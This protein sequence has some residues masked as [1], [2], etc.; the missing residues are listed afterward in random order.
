M[1]YCYDRRTGR[2]VCDS[3]GRSQDVR[4]RKCKYKVT[5]HTGLTLPYCYP[6]AL[7]PTCYKAEGGLSGVHGETCRTGAAASQARDDLVGATLAA[8]GAISTVGYG[9]W[10]EDVPA[11]MVGRGFQYLDGQMTYRL[12]PRD[13]DHAVGGQGFLADYSDTVEWAGPS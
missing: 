8:G 11:G 1:G 6:P 9:D 10:H 3:C 5:D 13:V 4:R 12:I 7:C 2:L